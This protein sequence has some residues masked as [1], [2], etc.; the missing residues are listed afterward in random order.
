MGPDRQNSPE[1]DGPGNL[2]GIDSTSLA[3]PTMLPHPIVSTGRP[4]KT[5]SVP[6][7]LYP[8]QNCRVSME[9][10]S[11]SWPHGRSLTTAISK[12]VPREAA[13]FILHTWQTETNS[14][15]NLARQKWA[16]WC[17]DK[18]PCPYCILPSILGASVLPR[19]EVS[20]IES[21]LI[22]SIIY[23]PPFRWLFIWTTPISV[24]TSERGI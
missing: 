5:P 21:V 1:G 2:N 16:Q 22:S 15:Y 19:E 14:N 8:S 24:Q 17:N 12:R 6:Q 7:T 3:K 4:P 10:I 11:H 23:T 20:F 13:D 9:G 18:L